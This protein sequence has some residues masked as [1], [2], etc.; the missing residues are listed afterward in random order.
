MASCKP[1]QHGV[2]GCKGQSIPLLRAADPVTL[3]ITLSITK[4]YNNSNFPSLPWPYLWKSRPI[5]YPLFK[6]AKHTA[7]K[8]WRIFYKNSYMYFFPTISCEKHFSI[9]FA[10]FI[11]LIHD[12]SV[13]IIYSETCFNLAGSTNRAADAEGIDRTSPQIVLQLFHLGFEVKLNFLYCFAVSL[14]C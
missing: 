4:T 13:S 2:A 11:F 3:L 10:L 7:E 9:N 8:S 5:P 14:P 1:R 12:Y 6:A